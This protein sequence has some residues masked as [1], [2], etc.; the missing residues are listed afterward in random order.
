MHWARA[1]AAAGAPDLYLTRSA[2]RPDVLLRATRRGGYADASVA[3]GVTAATA[4]GSR[5]VAVA[6]FNNDG[7]ADVYVVA[8]ATPRAADTLLLGTAPGRPF[9]AVRVAPPPPFVRGAAAGG[10]AAGGGSATPRRATASRRS[11]RTRTGGWMC[12]SGMGTRTTWPGRV[13]GGCCATR[14]RRGGGG[15]G[16]YL[17]L[18]VG[19]SPAGRASALGAVVRVAARG[20]GRRGGRRVWWRR[21]GEGGPVFSQSV[22]ELVHVGLGTVRSVDVRVRWSDGGVATAR[23]VPPSGKGG[24]LALGRPRVVT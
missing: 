10:R 23:A 24:V 11:T 20:G 7:E 4:G 6:D 16:G 2:G 22:N 12:C 3:A 19:A 15:G 17:A 21:V 9:R 18:R 14:R 5:G 8:T 1:A 13:C